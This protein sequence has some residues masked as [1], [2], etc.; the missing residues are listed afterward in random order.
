MPACAHTTASKHAGEGSHHGTAHPSNEG[1]NGQRGPLPDPKT[2]GPSANLRPNTSNAIG[3]D[4]L[5]LDSQLSF[6]KRMARPN[7]P[8][9]ESDRRYVM[10]N[11][12][13]NPESGGVAEAALVAGIVRAV[14]TPPPASA[15][16]TQAQAMSLESMCMDRRLDLPT[17]LSDNP[18]LQRADLAGQV[19]KAMQALP[20]SDP[21]KNSVLGALKKQALSWA[22]V[23]LAILGLEPKPLPGIVSTDATAQ[24]AASTSPIPQTGDKNYE[25]T[26]SEAQTLAD[27]GDYRE[28]V[29]KAGEV[30]DGHPLKAKSQE[31]VRDYSNQAVQDL[32]R[33]AALAFQSALP[34]SDTKTKSGYLKQAKAYLEDAIK[35]FPDATQLPTVQDNLRVIS[36]DLE[37]LEIAGKR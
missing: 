2:V 32:R 20:V 28:A 23:N 36:S 33:K 21:F 18:L 35:N 15:A 24:V 4:G 3:A 6:F 9:G 26:L 8:F 30:P 37:K 31:K 10:E 29:K 14:L 12:P 27:K 7:G 25:G 11:L 17:A 16:A 22:D 5:P 19:I 1:K 13:K 34:V